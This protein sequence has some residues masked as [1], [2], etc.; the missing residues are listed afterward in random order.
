MFAR[1]ANKITTFK[2]QDHNRKLPTYKEMQKSLFI[3]AAS[4]QSGWVV[5]RSMRSGGLSAV[6]YR[7]R[8]Y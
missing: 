5:Q 1:S 3:N 4:Y 6:D 7:S 2:Q 8:K